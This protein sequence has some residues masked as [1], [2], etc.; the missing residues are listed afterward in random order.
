M[1]CVAP[2]SKGGDAIHQCPR[3]ESWLLRGFVW[4]FDR[5]PGMCYR[6]GMCLLP[7]LHLPRPRHSPR[8]SA[9]LLWTQAATP[10]TPKQSP[11][12]RRPPRT[13]RA[14]ARA[15]AVAAAAAAHPRCSSKQTSP[16]AR[17]KGR[18]EPLS[19]TRTRNLSV[20]TNNNHPC[21]VRRMNHEYDLILEQL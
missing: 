16:Q 3:A 20:T 9:A 12:T 15:L 8:H 2:P 18:R 6:P 1:D 21:P 5:R 7:P 17:R 10:R 11:P 14:S 4:I 13:Q 19:R